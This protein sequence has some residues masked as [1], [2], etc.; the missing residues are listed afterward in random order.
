MSGGGHAGGTRESLHR[1]AQGL[2]ERLQEQHKEGR[3]RARV[4]QISAKLLCL[5][6]ATLSFSFR[7]VYLFKYNLVKVFDKM[8]IYIFL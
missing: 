6:M 1:T 4:L 2:R 3:A 5:S 7:F 8:N